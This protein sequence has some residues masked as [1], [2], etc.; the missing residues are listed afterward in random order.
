MG[1]LWV[2]LNYINFDDANFYEDDPKPVFHLRPLAWHNRLKQHKT[3]K[4]RNKQ[5]I[6]ASAMASNKMV[7][8]VHSKRRKERNR[9]VLLMKGSIKFQPK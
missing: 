5:R 8:L 9:T 2:D 7:R 1:I 4:N 6:N 3:F